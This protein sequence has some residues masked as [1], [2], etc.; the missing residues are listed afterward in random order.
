MTAK[1]KNRNFPDKDTLRKYLQGKLSPEAAHR[2]E[3]LILNN[4]F[5]LDA[6]EGIESLEED[7]VKMDIETVSQKLEDR[8]DTPLAPVE[9]KEQI[10]TK[11]EKSETEPLDVEEPLGK[12][13]ESISPQAV[14]ADKKLADEI[15][16]PSE[17]YTTETPELTVEAAPPTELTNEFKAYQ[18]EIVEVDVKEIQPIEISEEKTATDLD[19]TPDDLGK[20]IEISKEEILRQERSVAIEST[21]TRKRA[22]QSPEAKSAGYALRETNA[23]SEE[24]FSSEPVIGFDTYNQ[25][26]KE[27]L[28]YPADAIKDNIEG[29][30]ELQFIVDKDSI[31]TEIKVIKSLSTSCDKEA[32]RLLKDGPK[33]K[34]LISDGQLI[35]SEV[36]YTITFELK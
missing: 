21:K 34:P 23:I 7:E 15:D 11:T 32:V 28:N 26:I 1:G 33:W 27:N 19:S 2:I 30:V 24:D 9:S 17:E 6:F 35:E 10:I 22:S 13:Q 25:Y 14:P 8:D 16:I 12:G 31:P 36:H 29:L 4:E 3:K 18:P 20:D 5:Y